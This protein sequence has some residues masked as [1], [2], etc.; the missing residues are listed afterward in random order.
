M[1]VYTIRKKR[2]LWPRKD[3]TEII[4]NMQCAQSTKCSAKI[5]EDKVAVHNRQNDKYNNRDKTITAT[6]GIK[7]NTQQNGVV[8]GV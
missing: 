1:Q 2:S 6:Q 3:I 5:E 8:G 4:D 7:Y